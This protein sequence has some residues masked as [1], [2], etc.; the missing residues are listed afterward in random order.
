MR[1]LVGII[2]P[3]II[4]FINV[5][6][7]N[8]TLRFWISLIICVAV[9][10]LLNIDKLTGSTDLPGLLSK[11]AITFTEAQIVYKT[12]YEKSSLRAK[13]IG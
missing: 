8:S 13:I 7:A 10:T 3:P 5:H 6:I 1:D 4:D 9:A 12:Y 11:I 2:L